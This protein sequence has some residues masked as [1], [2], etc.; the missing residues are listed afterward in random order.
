ME[1]LAYYLQIGTTT[2]SAVFALVFVFY[3]WNKNLFNKLLSI[4]F[5]ILSFGLFIHFLA[6]ND[7]FVLFPHLSRTG[8]LCAFL[9]PPIQF[10]AIYKGLRQIKLQWKDTLHFLPALLYIINYYN[11]FILSESEKLLLL[12]NNS[13][14]EFKEGFLPA[15]FLPMLSILQT[16][17][18]LVWFGFMVKKLKATIRS[19]YLLQFTF[20]IMFHMISQYLPVIMVAL[21]YHDE[22]TINN[23]LPIVYALINIGFFF[24][25]LATPEW[26]LFDSEIGHNEEEKNNKMTV[27]SLRETSPLEASLIAKLSPK[28]TKLNYEEKQLFDQFTE[29][30]EVDRLFLQPAFSQKNI[31]EKLKV[32]EYKIRLLIDKAY[33]MKFSEFSN[34]RK[35]YFL[36]NEMQKNPQWQRYSYVAI[37]RKLGYLSANSFYLN[38]KKISGVTPKEYFENEAEVN[39]L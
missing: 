6:L 13:L 28:K 1:K 18:Y 27:F 21:Y 12:E 3:N 10:L 39:D 17:F 33:E 4:Q 25:I 11:Y 14:A 5:V 9:I 15:F 30:V 36:L 2:S 19:K 35:T 32:S 34:Y 22:H 38:F 7:F 23:W 16:S 29:A 37:A 26:L 31:A 8:L 24:K 20:F